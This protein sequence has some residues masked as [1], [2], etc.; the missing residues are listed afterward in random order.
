MNGAIDT[1]DFANR[2]SARGVKKDEAEAIAQEVG[3]FI[4]SN[5]TRPDALERIEKAMATKEDA[6]ELRVGQKFLWGA[7]GALIALVVGV[8]W[9]LFDMSA[10][11]A[12]MSAQM[13]AMEAQMTVMEAQMTAISA[14]LA[15]ISSALS[16]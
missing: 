14:D 1:L 3:R 7:T 11:F 10:D 2:L 13:V 9:K 16:K 6:A 15:A 4:A 12:A 5:A 8:I